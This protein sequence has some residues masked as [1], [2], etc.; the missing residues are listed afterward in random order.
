MAASPP[1]SHCSNRFPSIENASSFVILRLTTSPMPATKLIFSFNLLGQVASLQAELA[2]VQSQL[3]NSR[4]AAANALHHHGPEVQP[5]APPPSHHQSMSVPMIQQ[6]AYS[7]TS[8]ASTTNLINGI[9]SS[10]F[11]NPNNFSDNN[12]V[13]RVNDDT[14][15]NGDNINNAASS[16]GHLW[17]SSHGSRNENEEGEEPRNGLA[18]VRMLIGRT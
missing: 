8:S 17:T 5:P 13:V 14:N 4:Y 15:N 6:P 18:A 3:I 1:F 16:P 12:I 11:S 9:D 10:S 7:N 2:M